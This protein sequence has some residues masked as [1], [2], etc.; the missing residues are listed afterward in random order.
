MTKLHG[1]SLVDFL[2]LSSKRIIKEINDNNCR[3]YIFSSEHLGKLR[4]QDEV[5]RLQQFLSEFFSDFKIIY[6]ARHPWSACASKIAEQVKVNAHDLYTL[7]R[8]ADP[9]F[10]RFESD[11][12]IWQAVFPNQ[13]YVREFS[14]S[15]LAQVDL[16][17]DFLETTIGK[18]VFLPARTKRISANESL[19]LEALLLANCITKYYPKGSD[20][21]PSS[22]NLTAILSKIK[23]RKFSLPRRM[24]EILDLE[25]MSDL[26]Y[27]LTNYSIE[28]QKPSVV[29]IEIE[30][31][32]SFSAEAI[33]SL[34]ILVTSIA[35][36]GG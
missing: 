36:C 28:L 27:L 2:T 18:S 9:I 8:A 31:Y 13:I 21:R 26:R 4:T 20:A 1:P 30:E 11:L 25:S 3:Y 23:G 24:Y 32:A 22:R 15:R 16:V 10:D 17:D 29:P 34:A 7:V 33:D 35:E 5:L 12:A 14:P 6:Y 19:S